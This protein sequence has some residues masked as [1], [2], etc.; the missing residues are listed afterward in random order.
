MKCT[1]W[2]GAGVQWI[3]NTRGKEGQG[4]GVVNYKCDAAVF[5]NF[6]QNIETIVLDLMTGTLGNT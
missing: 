3:L 2:G 4:S 5:R 6:D 1:G